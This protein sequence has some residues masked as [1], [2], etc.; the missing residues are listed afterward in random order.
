MLTWRGKAAKGMLGSKCV[1]HANVLDKDLFHVHYI[2]VTDNQE[3]VT[4][5]KIMAGLRKAK[6]VNYGVG[7]V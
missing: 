2:Y 5:E 3:E 1:L 4:E 6:G 7:R